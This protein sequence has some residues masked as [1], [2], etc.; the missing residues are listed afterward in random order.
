MLIECLRRRYSIYQHLPKECSY[1]F[2]GSRTDPPLSHTPQSTK[3][4]HLAT[5]AVKGKLHRVRL[6][7]TLR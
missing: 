2:S 6:R 4:D 7:Q 3:N 1:F 5:Y